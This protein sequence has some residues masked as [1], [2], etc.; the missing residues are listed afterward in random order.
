[1]MDNKNIMILDIRVPMI[2]VATLTGHKNCVN[3]ISWAPHSCCHICSA[4]D[5]CQALIWDLSAIP[6]PIDDPILA[7]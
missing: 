7:Y 1:M 2:P 6:T 4:G 5:D 3:S